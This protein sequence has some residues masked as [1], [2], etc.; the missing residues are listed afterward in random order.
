L[1]GNTVR[2]IIADGDEYFVMY[3]SILLNR[4]GID[5]IIPAKSGTE[6]LKLLKIITP[7]VVILNALMPDM[8]GT[9]VIAQIR[10][11]GSASQVPVILVADSYSRRDIEE[12]KELDISGFLTKPVRVIDIF[13]VLH[14]CIIYGGGRKRR[15]MRAPFNKKVSVRH[16]RSMQEYHAVS[17][18]E[19]GLYVGT[20]DPPEVGEEV[21]VILPIRN[22]QRLYLSGT[23][24]YHRGMY[25]GDE[26]SIAP[27]MAI[28]FKDVK[29]SD[30]DVLREYVTELLAKDLVE[31]QKKPVLSI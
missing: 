21:S 5:K 8:D 4:M 19:G 7:N 10:D 11:D 20:M 31:E 28:Q 12:Y 9:E 13:T 6:A 24:I 1:S 16:N 26:M 14:D 27:G 22:G 30:S 29:A 17:L 25:G 2:I 18:S 23:V 15:V 3:V